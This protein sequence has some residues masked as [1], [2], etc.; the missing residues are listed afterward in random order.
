MQTGKQQFQTDLNQ[1][2]ISSSRINVL[3]RWYAVRHLRFF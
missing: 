3:P 1:I 2:V